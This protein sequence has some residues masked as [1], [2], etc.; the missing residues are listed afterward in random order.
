[1]PCLVSSAGKKTIQQDTELPKLPKRPLTPYIQFIMCHRDDIRR[2]HPTLT[3]KE[4]ESRLLRKWQSF[5]FEERNLWSLKYEREK[6][7]YDKQYKEV[8]KKLDSLQ[9]KQTPDDRI[10]KRSKQKLKLG[11]DSETMTQRLTKDKNSNERKIECEYLGK[12]KAPRNS[13]TLYLNTVKQDGVQ[14]K[15]FM[16]KASVTWKKLPEEEKEIF[17]QKAKALQE[18]YQTD[19]LRWETKMCEMGRMDLIRSHQRAHIR[20]LYLK[21]LRNAT[22]VHNIDLK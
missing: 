22:Y 15:N 2:E 7:E 18:Q 17:R 1:M 20:Q 9:I 10:Q 5:T 4:V 13:F 14:I 12:P 19:L 21:N 11:E 3:R 16:R 6:A 8:M